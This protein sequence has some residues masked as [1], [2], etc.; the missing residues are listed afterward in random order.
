MGET[1]RTSLDG[2][3][4]HRRTLLFVL[5]CVAVTGLR[6]YFCTRTPIST[7]DALRHIFTGLYVL[8]RGPG[9]AGVPLSSLNPDLK[10]LSF[11]N[12]P[13][14]YP[15]VAL[16]FFTALAAIWPAVVTIKL[17]LTLISAGNAW[18]LA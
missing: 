1:S 10:Y 17:A 11:A 9:I 12:L 5:A 3:A 18:M 4:R 16:A 13:Y 2:P 14:N 15:P 6:L 7:G 8:K